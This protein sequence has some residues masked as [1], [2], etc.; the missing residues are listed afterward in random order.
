MKVMTNL[1]L[2]RNQLING[3]IQQ[4]SADPTTKLKAGWIIFNTD[5]AKLKYYNGEEWVA[6][7]SGGGGTVDI[8]TTITNTSTNA[9][10]A[11]AKAV[12]DFVTDEMSDIRAVANGLVLM[13]D[14]TTGEVVGITVD[15]TV[16][17]DSANLITSGAVYTAISDAVSTMDAMK[18]KGTVAADGTITS[19]DTDIDG[20]NITALTTYKNGWTFKATATIP[21]SV[22]SL[23]K[24]VEP[25]DMIIVCADMN[26]YDET[27]IAVIQTNLDGVVIGPASATDE[28]IAVYDGVTGKAIKASVI[29]KTQLEGLF[30]ELI[31]LE[32]QANATDVYLTSSNNADATVVKP[33]Q[34]MSAKL[35]ST[36]VTADE[37]GSNVGIVDGKVDDGDSFT[38]PKFTVD[39][40]GRLTAAAN[41]TITL[42]LGSKGNIARKTNPALT[43]DANDVCEWVIDDIALEALPSVNLYV[44]STGEMVLAD[45]TAD[46][47]ND[48]ITITFRNTADISAGTYTA[49]VVS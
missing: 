46:V 3:V 40:K 12:Y 41:Q 11:G 18:F 39:A 26:A 17:E 36:G 48:E 22:T 28:T 16:T 25:G 33:G 42:D 37:Y 44:T 49:V 5:E 4:V 45:V 6:I 27:K 21:T 35:K 23:D 29:T 1:D 7:G 19:T 9:K 34:T 24:P 30:D 10:A 20:L 47:T 8:A 32:A 15:T 13:T 14:D 38:I 43:A 31:N 2:L